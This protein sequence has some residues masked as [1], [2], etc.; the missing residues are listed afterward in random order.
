M[1][2]NLDLI[3]LCAEHEN[4]DLGLEMADVGLRENSESYRLRVD[5]GIVL[6]L[7]GRME[8][9]EKEFARAAQS[10][11]E[12]TIAHLARATALLELNRTPKPSS[13]FVSVA[14]PRR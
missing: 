6:G 3:A 4:Y 9:A 11:P 10:S 13:C 1:P 2:P 7:L 8:E 5:R 12:Q 14:T